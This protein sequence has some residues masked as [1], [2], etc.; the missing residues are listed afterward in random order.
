MTGCNSA[1]EEPA[2]NEVTIDD[3]A[4]NHLW[5]KTVGDINDDGKM[6]MLVGG[7]QS[8]G[9]VAYLAP[10]WRKQV[11]NDSIKIST[12]AE[13]CDLNNDKV[14]DIV[15]V[16]NQAIV[17]FKGPDWS[18]HHID[19]VTGHDVEVHDFDDDGLLDIVAR[20]QG[21][22]GDK[23]GHT[24][25]FYKQG[26]MGEWTRHEK[27]IRD[28]EGLKMADI[29]DDGR[30][31]IVTN[32]FW[33]ENTGNMVAWNE[34]K[35]TDS[36]TWPNTYID[37]AD[38][39]GDGR[40]DILHSPAELAKNYYRIS[41]FE[42]PENPTSVWKEH[43][44]ADSIET[45]VHSIAAAD[46]DG[47][48]AMDIVVAEMQQG[49]DPDEVAIFYNKGDNAWEKQVISTG[50][51]HSMVVFDADGDG[52]LDIFGANFAEN[53]VRMWVNQKKE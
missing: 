21:A 35:F 5:M 36:W 7:W 20:N 12:N 23:G 16:I 14:P 34:H 47:D 45:I 17:W 46:F 43:I 42:A 4:P 8:G 10:D 24:L 30:P 32:G 31:D 13:V 1:P 15:A 39:N 40:P 52:D 26:P 50:G 6:D 49:A 2:F 29:N 19:S 53:V 33:F 25:F 37:V 18:I 27:E 28:G 41:W 51:G 38:I 9:L 44:V 22:F 48:G 3:Q 11:I